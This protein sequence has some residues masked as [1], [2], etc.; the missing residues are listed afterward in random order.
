MSLN[1]N[2]FHLRSMG[3]SPDLSLPFGYW[4]LLT[5]LRSLVISEKSFCPKTLK[6]YRSYHGKEAYGFLLEVICGLHS[7][8]LGETEILGQFKDFVSKNE[9]QFSADLRHSMNHLLRL[10][11]KIRSRY[12]QNLG[13]S[14][15]GSL[16]RKHLKADSQCSAGL[17]PKSS[18][19]HILGAGS[20]SRDLLPWFVKLDMGI[21]VYTRDPKASRV[22]AKSDPNLFFHPL[23]ALSSGARGTLVIAAPLKSDWLQRVVGV[24][25]FQRIYDLRGESERDPLNL[26]NVIPLKELFSSIQEGQKRASL[27][28]KKVLQV[29][30]RHTSEMVPMEKQR[31]FGWEDLWICS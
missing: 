24:G 8:M 4:H 6:A 20:L 1:L 12:L 23:D 27:I 19:L 21:H 16:L 2:L 17:D 3:V 9:D 25:N 11:K 29:I 14:S 15:Y 10:A 26:S 7:P 5:C 18:G 13:C 30:Q 28:K 31:P 22:L